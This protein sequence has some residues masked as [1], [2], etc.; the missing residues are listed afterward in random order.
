MIVATPA[1]P[2]RRHRLTGMRKVAK[3]LRSPFMP[4]QDQASLVASELA[5][6]GPG[7]AYGTVVVTV[8]RQA[9]KTVT[10][11]VAMVHRGLTIPSHQAWYTAQTREDAR[12][13]FLDLATH[14]RHRRCPIRPPFTTI[15]L[16]NGSEGMAWP[17]DSALRLFAPTEAALH[18]EAL[19]QVVLDESWAHSEVLGQA[20]LGAAVPGGLTRPWFQLWIVSTAGDASSTWLRS[21]VDAGRAAVESGARSGI[22]YFETRA[23]GPDREQLLDAHP[24]VGHTTTRDRLARL[25]DAAG[26]DAPR[27]FGNLWPDENPSGPFPPGTW[28]RRAGDVDPP[29]AGPAAVAIDVAPD[30]ST[31]AVAVAWPHGDATAAA[32]AVAGA[33]VGW[34]LEHAGRLSTQLHA[35]VTYDE[36]SA[37]AALVDSWPK[38]IRT[39]RM[40]TRDVTTAA[41]QLHDAVTGHG[42]ALVVRPD[43]TLDVA[44]AGAVTR[45]VGDAWAWGR[46]TSTADITT[47]VAVTEACWSLW[48]PASEPLLIT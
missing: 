40:G 20:L 39:R 16:S 8:P 15:R 14:V 28:S 3:A 4:W 34:V 1:T 24:A 38:T 41:Q 23:E 32:V 10:S 30:R 26:A 19:D 6:D 33:G 37:A 27:A 47:L 12:R 22:A 48:H 36:R 31:A 25:I 5:D 21:F 17:N 2:G 43:P 44:V 42:H 11:R 45:P 46:R 29:A 7:W 13:R 18:G 9:G 35:P